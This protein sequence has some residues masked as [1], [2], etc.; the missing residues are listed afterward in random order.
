MI[1][2]ICLGTVT[3]QSYYN[4]A[5]YIPYVILYIPVTDL[6]CNWKF[7]PLN[8]LLISPNP[9]LPSP[10]ATTGWFSATYPFLTQDSWPQALPAKSFAPGSP[11]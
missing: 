3:M 9:L 11:T 10:L 7:L 6:F 1:T 2:M 4:I 8:S 5:D